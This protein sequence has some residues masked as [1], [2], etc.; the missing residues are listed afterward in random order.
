M[1]SQ[2]EHPEAALLHHTSVTVTDPSVCF[3]LVS[4]RTVG[5]VMWVGQDG[6]GLNLSGG[7]ADQ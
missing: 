1:P 7:V 3:V 5:M 6:N 2:S 4:S